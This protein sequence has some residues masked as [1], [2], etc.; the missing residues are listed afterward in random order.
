MGRNAT[1]LLPNNQQNQ[2]TFYCQT[3]NQVPDGFGVLFCLDNNGKSYFYECYWEN[4]RPIKGKLSTL[5]G[6]NNDLVVFKGEFKNF[7]LSGLGSKKLHNQ[8]VYEGIWKKGKYH[9]YGIC[10]YPGGQRYEG[11]MLN[12]QRHGEGYYYYINGLYEFGIYQ[13]DREEGIHHLYS[14]RHRLQQTTKYARGQVVRIIR[15]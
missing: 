15:Y 13:R 9:Q 10:Y 5:E 2:A 4:G 14:A 7:Q 1:R 11:E 3:L 8:R 12:G 6:P